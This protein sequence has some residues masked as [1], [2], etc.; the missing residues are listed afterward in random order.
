MLELNN[1]SKTCFYI[2]GDTVMVMLVNVLRM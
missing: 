1:I 2:E